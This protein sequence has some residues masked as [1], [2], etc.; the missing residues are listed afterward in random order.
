MFKLFRKYNK[1]ILVWGGCLLMIAFLV[2]Q[3]LTQ[4]AGGGGDYTIGR[5]DTGEVTEFERRGAAFQLEILQQLPLVNQFALDLAGDRDAPLKWEL[6]RRDAQR[7]GLSASPYEASSIVEFLAD[8]DPTLMQRLSANRGPSTEAVTAAVQSWLILD[9][10]AQLVRGD[11]FLPAAER[12]KLLV[13]ARTNQNFEE[14]YSLFYASLGGPRLSSSLV[15]H[16]LQE[17]GAT[18][19]GEAVL[20]GAGR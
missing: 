6:M 5:T 14:A 13:E 8:L 18:V 9:R 10:Y 2:P 16:F 7:L 1:V 11:S 15:E 12:L 4:C 3:S 19:W 17:Q 20:I